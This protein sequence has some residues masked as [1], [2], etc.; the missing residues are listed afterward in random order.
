MKKFLFDCG[1]RDVTA[2]VGLFA[3]RVMLGLMMLI[4][5]GIYK[6]QHFEAL[7]NSFYVPE[8][9]P[10]HYMSPLVSLSAC[11]VAEVLCS[12]LIIFGIATRHAAFI[13]AFSMVVA[14]FAV[15]AQTPWFVLPPVY[16]TKELAILYIIPLI[17]IIIT[18]AGWISMDA[19]LYLEEKRRRW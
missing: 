2:S 6:I 14:A 4:G 17:A 9:F 13:L 19:A 10:F 11:I 1:T 15:K 5:H 12:L 16:D 8:F 7:K 3:L 18:G